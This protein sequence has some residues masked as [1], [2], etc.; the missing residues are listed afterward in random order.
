MQLQIQIP[1]LPIQKRKTRC[2]FKN[3]FH[4]KT[5]WRFQAMK[6]SK[7]SQLAHWLRKMKQMKPRARNDDGR[8]PSFHIFVIKA[9]EIIKTIRT[10]PF[11]KTLL[12]HQN[13]FICPA[14]KNFC[15]F[16]KNLVIRAKKTLKKTI[17]CTFCRKIATFSNF[18]EIQAF[19]EK[20]HVC[21]EENPNF[22]RFEESKSKRQMCYKLVKRMQKRERE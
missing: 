2:F 1:I 15:F 11:K 8:S 19:L 21:F 10:F 17:S 18:K 4:L 6:K 12:N 20:T 3:H 22:Q 5:I 7:T 9:F 14:P 16:A 13:F